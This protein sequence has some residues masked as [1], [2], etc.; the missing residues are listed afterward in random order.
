MKNGLPT[1]L[2]L[3][4]VVLSLLLSPSRVVAADGKTQVVAAEAYI[5]DHQLVTALNV[6]SAIDHG[7]SFALESLDVSGVGEGQ[8]TVYLRFQDDQGQWSQ[9]VG[10]S[11]YMYTDG[12]SNGQGGSNKLVLAEMFV[13]SNPGEGNGLLALVPK[14]GVFDETFE[15][16]RHS[17]LLQGLD[18]GTHTLH[19]RF[20]DENGNWSIPLAQTF[21]LDKKGGSSGGISAG[22]DFGFAA[23]E[24]FFDVDPGQGNGLPL[25]DTKTGSADLNGDELRGLANLAAL[26][27]GIHTLHVRY[28][29]KSGKWSLPHAQ[30]VYITSR[31]SVSSEAGEG[32]APIVSADYAIDDG[33]FQPAPAADGAFGGMVELVDIWV[34]LNPAV[35]HSVKVRFNDSLGRNSSGATISDATPNDQDW[36]GLPDAWEIAHLG[37]TG[38]SANDDPDADGFSNAREFAN[39]TDPLVKDADGVQTISGFV[40]GA[41][42]NGLA[43]INLCIELNVT[44]TDCSVTTD[45]NGHYVFGEDNSLAP[46]TYRIYPATVLPLYGFNPVS[47]TVELGLDPVA[48]VNFNVE[49][50]AISYLSPNEVTT[51]EA[52]QKVTLVWAGNGA[53]DKQVVLSMKRD[54]VPATR[55]EPLADDK[56]WYQ[57]TIDTPNDGTE[58]VTIP[59]G[60]N[61]ADDWRFHVGYAGTSIASSATATF[62]YDEP[63]IEFPLAEISKHEPL[64]PIE[65]ELLT[66]TGTSGADGHTIV[67]HYWGAIPLV[68]GVAAG[69]EIHMGSTAVLSTSEL[70][71]GDWRFVYR[72]LDDQG[73]SSEPVVLDLTV[74]GAEGLADL[75][76]DRTGIR[77][78]DENGKSVIQANPGDK[79]TIELTVRN[80]GIASFSGSYSVAAFDDMPDVGQF[81][82]LVS[83]RDLAAGETETIEIPWT[84]PMTQGY[85]SLVFRGVID[86]NA[87]TGEGAKLESN[88]QNNLASAFIIV[89][90][91]PPGSYGME[92]TAVS[93][94]T[95]VRGREVTFNGDAH[96]MWGSH[97]PVMGGLVTL[98]FNGKQNH[99]YTISPNGRFNI[100]ARA[101]D[102]LGTY[103]AKIR[104]YDNNLYAETKLL[105]TVID[106][107]ATPPPPPLC[108]IYFCFE[109][110]VREYVPVP[111]LLVQSR[112]FNFTGSEGLFTTDSGQRA[113]VLN[114]TVSLVA[115]I[116]NNGNLV[117]AGG[118]TVRFT[119]EI[120][121]EQIGEEIV[122]TGDVA[123]GGSV[124]ITS[125]EPITLD[126]LGTKRVH[127]YVSSVPGEKNLSNNHAGQHIEVR[128]NR[129]DLRGVRGLRFSNQP[130]AGDSV[131][132]L[133]DVLNRGPADSDQSFSVDYYDGHP[134]EGGVFLGSD[135]VSGN[136]AKG[137]VV[138]S[139]FTLQTQVEGYVDIHALID[140]GAAV[141]ED[142]E[143]NNIVRGN[144]YVCPAQLNQSLGLRATRDYPG[145]GE[146]IRLMAK[147]S[148][149]CG[150][151]SSADSVRFYNADPDNGG[152]LIGEIA[153]PELAGG[154]S[155]TADLA[156][157]TP[158]Y[159]GATTLYAQLQSNGLVAKYT[160]YIAAVT[161][162]MPDLQ[163]LSQ[164]IDKIHVN[165]NESVLLG[166]ALRN[167]SQ[168][169]P[170]SDFAVNF[171]VDS[172]IGLQKVGETIVH[173]SPLLPGQSIHLEAS[174][175][176][177][178]AAP[179]YAV[180]VDVIPNAEQGDA[181]IWNNSATTSFAVRGYENNEPIARDWDVE[182]LYNQPVVI[183]V[184][185]D[186]TDPENE[187]LSLTVDD[188]GLNDA[189]AV[190]NQD[191]NIVFTPGNDQTG[192]S[193]FTYTVTDA[194]GAATTKTVTVVI[195]RISVTAELTEKPN[196]PAGIVGNQNVLGSSNSLLVDLNCK[197]Q[198][199]DDKPIKIIQ[200]TWDFGD[201]TSETVS[202]GDDCAS[203][204]TIKHEFKERGRYKASCDIKTEFDVSKSSDDYVLYLPID[205]DL[206]ALP[207]AW[208][209]YGF[210]LDGDCIDLKAE[211]ALVGQRDLF[212]W[213]D[214][215]YKGKFDWHGNWKV[216]IDYSPT[217]AVIGNKERVEACFKKGLNENNHYAN[218]S[219]T[220]DCYNTLGQN[221]DE[222]FDPL[223][224]NSGG[225]SLLLAFARRGIALH[226][227][228]GGQKHRV[229]YS[230]VVTNAEI[231][232][233]LVEYKRKAEGRSSSSR[234]RA[235]DFTTAK[236]RVYR[237]MLS[238]ESI[239]DGQFK[240][241]MEYPIT[242][243]AN[244]SWGVVTG[245]DKSSV[246]I[247]SLIMHE[248]G[249]SLGLTHGGSIM[250]LLKVDLCSEGDSMVACLNEIK[251]NNK[252]YERIC[253]GKSDEEC[254]GLIAN[255]VPVTEFCFLGVET[256]ASCYFG[257]S[258]DLT[259][260]PVDLF[261][262]RAI[263]KRPNYLSIMNYI[264]HH[265]GLG[266]VPVRNGE[267]E[268]S[269]RSGL[270]DYSIFNLNTLDET[271]LDESDGVRG[272]ALSGNNDLDKLYFLPYDKG[273]EKY[274]VYFYKS[275][276]LNTLQKNNTVNSVN[277][278]DWN[279]DSKIED[280]VSVDINTSFIG[281]EKSEILMT[282]SDWDKLV[283]GGFKI[284]CEDT[285]VSLM[286]ADKGGQEVT[287]K[288][289][290]KMSPSLIAETQD[291]QRTY[292]PFDFSIIPFD[293]DI[294]SQKGS[295]GQQI[296]FTAILVNM[297]R[298][299]D[300]YSLAAKTESGWDVQVSSRVTV[301]SGHR[302]IFNV[303]V[304]IPYGAAIN[305][306]EEVVITAHSLGDQLLSLDNT[307][308]VHI[309]DLID[310]DSDGD[311]LSDDH[312]IAL[313]LDPYNPDTDADGVNDGIEVLDPSAPSDRNNNG[314]MDALDG[315][316][317]NPLDT[318][319]DGIGDE[320]EVALGLDPYQ[321]DSDGDG[322]NDGLEAFVPRADSLPVDFDKDGQ[323][324]ALEA[325]NEA[326]I[327]ASAIPGDL[328]SDGDV[329]RDD[330]N[331]MKPAFGQAANGPDD[332]ADINGDGVIN[333]LD[334][335]QAARLCTRPRCATR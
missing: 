163:V 157:Q 249:H 6:D 332:P 174:E 306:E 51:Y 241:M 329:D 148:N 160:I 144:L 123:P 210:C 311:S 90:T 256:L 87:A 149:R 286:C 127:V 113:A 93:P 225:E 55:N 150:L 17:S 302:Q 270:L 188:S 207:D 37:G 261:E 107:P 277:G 324:D 273:I 238:A 22:G 244:N 95:V 62:T 208:E 325:G 211:G 74:L 28:Q 29:N 278:I 132:I 290:A 218:N 194:S 326:F 68:N 184:L 281:S 323:I 48:Q 101:P 260:T 172:F 168:T 313:G 26:S 228:Y 198:S 190:I 272:S 294:L 220:M 274:A 239:D 209:T 137:E 229:D 250:G 195:R 246:K 196:A 57:F 115:Q 99:S 304:S 82:G 106:A 179:Y 251:L 129:P 287:V 2:R 69:D 30:S 77:F 197:T 64:L 201:G 158:S 231:D 175:S 191:G 307:F 8:H 305:L 269:L 117:A 9:A 275:G 202:C 92:M 234:G 297:G 126:M 206:D 85:Q 58:L 13:D 108:E 226:V 133:L 136:L 104:V 143:Y 301:K 176:F 181:D 314:I 21:Y 317:I 89:G 153:V 11:F 110:P 134:F 56:D 151:G 83:G 39:G 222:F 38:F 279:T 182:T 61:Q 255:P 102:E 284:G 318:D 333:V 161:V 47:R 293:Q 183:N 204:S 103:E 40:Y 23:A 265:E 84:V 271:S 248:F 120:S 12:K 4:V 139:T 14:D 316:D 219:L 298:K 283:F 230:S 266:G 105:I 114:S 236:E 162:P 15:R 154:A 7:F 322:I 252:A 1:F 203:N 189:S 285:D 122:Y 31:H 73:L 288:D 315:D 60:L 200:Y 97:L 146:N 112:Y 45:S 53:G 59:A 170:A 80:V 72:V 66:L 41:Q 177:I 169:T 321:P 254:W 199:L 111:D 109:W 16:L 24:A 327:K 3:F 152:L 242:M 42:G 35:P 71:A 141:D 214:H 331:L 259:G 267:D 263:N 79:V 171:Y 81:I 46:A 159:T 100:A 96:Y 215:M 186:V 221:M 180:L 43:G 291:T 253:K 25:S 86:G 295:A 223:S 121:G 178:A 289:P 227:D 164:D 32:Q 276:G 130:I 135:T 44:T 303:V 34:P 257:V 147:V 185:Q 258:K 292:A 310:V 124:G 264:Y 217:E 243:D 320:Q 328:D 213:I 247:K 70:A 19:L 309:T 50:L 187:I 116:E 193:E 330:L 33:V 235:D 27:P 233:D 216:T 131:D 280:N 166:T 88:R 262:Q 140:A 155:F 119:D 308:F 91:P 65:G 237:Y 5:N 63:S 335:R 10:Q 268:D 78:K 319:D 142:A 165:Q 98:D 156:W 245:F 312:E 232:N 192:Q 212:L 282:T 145:M 75:A 118:F 173:N 54:S 205:T 76:I 240:G 20:Q 138:R 167:L 49:T 67:E 224:D 36:D 18:K 94:V 125:S 300:V 299:D 128:K 296:T 334:F 52:G